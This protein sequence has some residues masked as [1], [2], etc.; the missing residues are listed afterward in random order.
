MRNKIL[1]IED[2]IHQYFVTKQ[3]LEAQLHLKVTVQ[4]AE[5]NQ[6]LLEQTV[7]YA[8]QTIIYR[9][10]GGIIELITKL[11]KKKANRLNAEVVLLVTPHADE[12]VVFEAKKIIKEKTASKKTHYSLT[13][14]A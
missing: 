1:I 7:E 6:E 14:A 13:H 3:V 5:D 11:K 8:P 10:A 9:S 12:N 2:N 4:G